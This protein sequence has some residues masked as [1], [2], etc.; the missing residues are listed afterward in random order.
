MIL[1]KTI[2]ILITKYNI[3]K[4]I[5][6]YPN[7]KIDKNYDIDISE[8]GIGSSY[9]I[10]A[11]CDYCG[12]KKEISLKNYYNNIKK[13]NK[14]ACC[15]KCGKLKGEETKL[16]IYGNKNYNN[17]EK[18]KN[19]MKEKYGVEHISQLSEI[20]KQK[21]DN[22]DQKS[23]SEKIKKG[24][25]R[26]RT[27]IDRK[28]INKKRKDTL[29]EKYNIENISQLESIKEKKA[30]TMQKYGGF[31]FEKTSIL[32]EQYQQTLFENYGVNNAA[33]SEI[34][35]EKMK[36]TNTERF[37]VEYASQSNTIKEKTKQTNLK[38][39]NV[40][41][42]MFSE[43]FRKNNFQIAQHKNYLYY[44][45]NQISVFSCDC[46]KEHTFKIHLDNFESRS[47]NKLP[48]CTICYPIS[49]NS[50]LKEKMLLKYIKNIYSGTIIEN[51]RDKIEID[52]YLPELNLGFE[53]NGLY[54]HSDKFID[55]DKHLK[56][57]NYFKDRN[58]RII[59]L[60][61][62]DWDFKN[63]IIKS[64]IK[65]WLNLTEE[66]I[67]GRT[68]TIKE[69][70]DI[71]LI[72]D[73]LNKNHIQGFVRSTKKY[74][75]F[76][77][78]ELV[79]LMT[80]DKFEGRKTMCDYEWNL[81]RFCNKL[82]TNVIGAASKLLKYFLKKNETKRL[83]SFADKEWSKGDLYYKLGFELISESKINYKYVIK[84][85]RQNKQQFTKKKL[86]K[87]GYDSSLTEKEIMNEISN[88]VYDCGQLKF[89]KLY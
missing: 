64:Q 82:N 26:K 43:K 42:I 68:T 70:T 2:N 63:N 25:K 40:E 83:I 13:Q 87:M 21:K 7:I 6:K 35:K 39:Y 59:Y 9:I 79:S 45:G 58:I 76:K 18:A 80:F 84:K 22:F 61:E 85:K 32:H 23:H 4:Y 8:F 27:E 14:F 29:L 67:Y 57:L 11:K 48:L 52:I 71:K 88:R 81:S 28:K 65:N 1:S 20:K 53:F 56:K 69:I 31:A 66:K 38:K 86:I 50:S 3:K 15:V 34:I 49:K 33:Q 78:G 41:N 19:T 5:T 75:L 54:W 12:N 73:F 77:D 10:T 44:I 60:W 36:Q 16:E 89:E 30:N 37:N 62:D 47:N 74:G 17:S 55:N 46:G 24:I 51:Y 72:K